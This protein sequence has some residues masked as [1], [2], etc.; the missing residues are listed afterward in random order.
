M[1]NTCNMLQYK[2]ASRVQVLILCEVIRPAVDGHPQ[3]LSS[4][5]Q[6]QLL[7]CYRPPGRGGNAHSIEGVLFTT[8]SRKEIEGCSTAA[9]IPFTAEPD[10]SILGFLSSCYISLLT[11]G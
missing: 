3:I 1:L 4:C 9:L 6:L 11:K 5:V 7:P 2:R 8:W 10:I